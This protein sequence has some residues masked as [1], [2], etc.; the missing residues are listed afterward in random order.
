MGLSRNHDRPLPVTLATVAGSTGS[1]Y[2]YRPKHCFEL[3]VNCHD[4]LL[5]HVDSGQGLV[6]ACERDGERS[7]SRQSRRQKRATATATNTDTDTDSDTDTGSTATDTGGLVRAL[8]INP[9][10]NKPKA[11]FGL[12]TI[13]EC[14]ILQPFS[15]DNHK[16]DNFALVLS[17]FCYATIAGLF[18]PLKAYAEVSRAFLASTVPSH[19]RRGSGGKKHRLREA[20]LDPPPEIGDPQ[21]CRC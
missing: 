2:P 16:S 17:A 8:L 19:Q 13:S 6:R 7:C 12:A 14:P 3:R 9:K 15:N 10:L 20:R 1:P 18:A 5:R 21:H 11:S 4:L